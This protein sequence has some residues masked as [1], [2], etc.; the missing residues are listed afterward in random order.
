MQANNKFSFISALKTN[1]AEFI[2]SEKSK[3]LLYI[4]Q[5]MQ[6]ASKINLSYLVRTE[7]QTSLLN[8]TFTRQ[9]NNTMMNVSRLFN[10]WRENKKVK[11]IESY[12][13]K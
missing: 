7:S 3:K 4:F 10:I 11:N 2:L 1:Q 5:A 12:I 13:K 8:K 9:C 6:H